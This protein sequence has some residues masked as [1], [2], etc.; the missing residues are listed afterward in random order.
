MLEAQSE[1][2]TRKKANQFIMSYLLPFGEPFVILFNHFTDR[3]LPDIYRTSLRLYHPDQFL[4]NS[5]T[6]VKT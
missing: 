3:L 4:R 2:D 1:E 6:T 5:R